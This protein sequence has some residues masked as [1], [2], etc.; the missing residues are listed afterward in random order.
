MERIINQF[1]NLTVATIGD[2]Q[3]DAATKVNDARG[4]LNNIYAG[5]DL[6]LSL[7]DNIKSI[8]IDQV[9]GFNR[10]LRD[11]KEEIQDYVQSEHGILNVGS[12][13]SKY[14]NFRNRIRTRVGAVAA[15]PELTQQQK[16]IIIYCL[17][18]IYYLP[19]YDRNYNPDKLKGEKTFSKMLLNV[20][21]MH[22]KSKFE[23][24]DGYYDFHQGTLA[25]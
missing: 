19:N 13:Y 1:N 8:T 4:I 17:L 12:Y 18:P 3:F 2:Q 7:K 25:I 10:K 23:Y 5:E 22:S 20:A 15:D 21:A 24:L 14:V 9:E 16:N 11:V 6:V